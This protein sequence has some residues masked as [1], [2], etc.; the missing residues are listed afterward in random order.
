[1]VSCHSPSFETGDLDHMRRAGELRVV[2]RPGFLKSPVH[3]L[4]GLDQPHMLRQLAARL[5]LRLRWIQASRND[6]LLPWLGEGRADL[7]VYRFSTAGVSRAGFVASAAL[8]WVDDLLIAS[9][10]STVREAVMLQN[11]SLDIHRSAQR[12]IVPSGEALRGFGATLTPIPEEVS[13]EEALRRLRGG[14]YTAMVLDSALLDAL[15]RAGIRVLKPVARQ[16]SLV[17]AIRKGN[18]RF[19]E[20]VDEF[21]FAEKV[22]GG[23]AHERACRD[24]RGIRRARVLRVVTRNAP[25]TTT[26]SLGGLRGFEYGLAMAFARSLGVRLQLVIPSRGSDPLDALHE[27]LGDLAALHEPLPLHSDGRFLS[28]GVYRR[29]DLV[30]VWAGNVEPPASVGDLGGRTLV[31]PSGF[32]SWLA[33][34]PLS[35]PIHVQPLPAGADVL[36]GLA[37]LERGDAQLG[38]ADSDTL[39]LELPDRP[40]LHRGPVVLPECGLRWAVAPGSPGLKRLASAFLR[41]AR[42]SGLMRRLELSELGG[43]GRWRP[44]RAPEIPPGRLTPFDQLL[45]EAGRQ[46]TLDWR[47][48]ASLMYEESR[49]DPHATGPGGSAGL[50]QLMPFTWQEL[51][52]TDPRDP[53]QAIIAGARYLRRLMDE[54][55]G[56]PMA[57]RVA[58]AIAGYNVGPRHVADARRL[59]REMGLD[60]NRWT[61]NVET[62]MLLLDN[63]DVARRFPAGVC[64]CRRA[65]GYTRRILRRYAAYRELMSP[66]GAP[67]L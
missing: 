36:S 44:P 55:R 20:A 21:L 64:R 39:Q 2:I 1:M 26:V 17:W 16:R 27:G 15:G 6:Q 46:N 30:C 67:G 66:V 4:D 49:F 23:E 5:G 33:E 43:K 12:W 18:P 14:R 38:V 53:R 48:L 65:V 41:R 42:R 13:L 51:G 3:S 32:Q 29:V 22:L 28:T 60:P 37:A 8:A 63:P 9:G 57:D 34:L 52:V 11:R 24:L 45:V 7:A 31:S 35:K 10:R 19:R 62:A 54:L 59:A 47:L 61:G 25:T 40:T 58:M 56:I 50:F